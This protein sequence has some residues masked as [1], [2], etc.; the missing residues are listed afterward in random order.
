MKAL[1]CERI[2]REGRERLSEA[3]LDIDI[4]TG[5]S[6]STLLEIISDYEIVIVGEETVLDASAIAAAKNLRIIAKAGTGFANID[7][8]ACRARNIRVLHTPGINAN[9]VAELVLGL[10]IDLVRG[11]TFADRSMRKGDWNFARQLGFELAGKTVSV[12]GFDAVGEAIAEK[13]S[14][15]RIN[16]L[17]HTKK[18]VGKNL[19]EKIE[20]VSFEKALSEAEIV[21]L[22]IPDSEQNYHAISEAEFAIMKNGVILVNA[23]CQG[24]LD[25]RALVEAL[26]S[27]KVRA[28]SLDVFEDGKISQEHPL[29]NFDN[30]ILTP[31][32][33]SLTQEAQ[34]KIAIE[35]ADK[36]IRTI[37]GSENS[38][39]E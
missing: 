25:E 7:I 4:Q 24:V 6:H 29:L 32:L 18:D 30:V 26:K 38:A 21:V 2:A 34:R 27:G 16:V 17:A 13:C 36:I 10:I 33:A 22:A 5:L 1:I 31:Q 12:I 19:F 8:A 35:I 11:I 3:G 15:L 14:A 9:A 23:S 20:L 37:A 28:A 39:Y